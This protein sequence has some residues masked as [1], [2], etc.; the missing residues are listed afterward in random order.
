[1]DK[2]PDTKIS[3]LCEKYC[4]VKYL[5]NRVRDPREYVDEEKI[6]KFLNEVK[7]FANEA[8]AS[9]DVDKYAQKALKVKSANILANV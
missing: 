8:V 2:N 4:G 5:K 6:G 9:G 1:M 7:K 3:Q